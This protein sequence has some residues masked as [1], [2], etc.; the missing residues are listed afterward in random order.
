MPAAAPADPAESARSVPAG[1]A[2][3]VIAVVDNNPA[4][5]HWIR[6]A[7]RPLAH[8]CLQV[9]HD[10]AS[11]LEALKQGPLPAAALVDH[12]MPGR[13]GLQLGAALSHAGGPSGVPWILMT[14]LV[15]DEIDLQARALG[16]AEVLTK[17]MHASD[18]RRHVRRLLQ[19]RDQSLV[20]NLHQGGSLP[21]VMLFDVLARVSR[22]RDD[23]TGSHVMRMA[24]YAVEIARQLG[25]PDDYLDH[26]LLA[27]PLHDI[28]KIG[29]PDR[30]L[31]KRGA[32]D[33]EE[34]GTM[35]RHP[36]YGAAVL[37]GDGSAALTMARHIAAAHH[38]RFDGQGYPE[39][40][41]GDAIPL[42][43][44]IVAVADVFDALT[45]RRPY[46]PAWEVG[47]AIRF[48][49]DGAGR[50]FDPAV[51]NAFTRA[52]PRILEVMQ[53]LADPLLGDEA[54]LQAA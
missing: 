37:R 39:G 27:A 28:G 34:M 15:D 13:D 36:A 3:R 26:L 53:G 8:T 17:P 51:V 50:H 2:P 42:E 22:L 54:D 31:N 7:L 29:V 49:E 35:R 19:A 23:T 52:L 33:P 10:A 47:E 45:T 12:G 20:A 32:L 18:L 40:L 30:I 16:A 6:A 25:K 46:K 14:G 44:R 24:R 9:H 11:F 5:C 43:A 38:E 48:I 21:E 1:G 41:S 4:H